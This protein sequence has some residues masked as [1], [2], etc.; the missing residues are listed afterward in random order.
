MTELTWITRT[1]RFTAIALGVVACYLLSY[2]PAIRRSD[3]YDLVSY[4]LFGSL[5]GDELP[6]YRPV[7]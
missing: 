6:V 7:D 4:H 2:A 3:R 1:G 5:D